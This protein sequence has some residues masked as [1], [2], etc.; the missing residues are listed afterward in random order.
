MIPDSD[1]RYC[2]H[3]QKTVIDFTG[4]SDDEL[5]QFLVRKNQAVCGRLYHFQLNRPIAPP[6]EP[7]RSL[8]RM[9]LVLGLSL[10]FVAG[11][12]VLARP[13]P[14]LI[15]SQVV[16]NGNSHGIK[17]DGMLQ[18]I[19]SKGRPLKNASVKLM[20]KG[21]V[22]Y[23]FVTDARGEYTVG[24]IKSGKYNLRIGCVGYKTLQIPSVE[25]SDKTRRRDVLTKMEK[26]MKREM[27]DTNVTIIG[28]IT[29][30]D[31]MGQFEV[32]ELDTTKDNSEDLNSE[33]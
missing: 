19:D 25:L 16:H 5:Y 14:P 9:S 21:N 1:G 28:D 29:D 31:V 24:K 12:D 7:N 11:G 23:S 33:R 8:F 32:I 20:Q 13:K 27:L 18:I 2:S 22:I 30:E 4:W 26:V 3:C 10:L 6:G 17:M 15:D